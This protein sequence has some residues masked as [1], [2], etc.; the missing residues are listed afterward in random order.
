MTA[1]RRTSVLGLA[2]LLAAA[3]AAAD[4][5]VTAKEV[6]SC[7]VESVSADSV[8]LALKRRRH[9]TLPAW[10]V[11]EVRLSDTARVAELA[12]LL[13]RTKV[14]LDSGQSVPPPEVRTREAMR[15]RLDRTRE[16]RLEGLPWHADVVDTLARRTSPNEMAV[17]CEDMNAALLECGRSDGTVVQLLREVNREKEALYKI[18]PRAVTSDLINGGCFGGLVGLGAGAG[19]GLA[20]DPPEFDFW[21]GGLQDCGG[22]PAGATVGCIAGPVIGM[23]IGAWQRVNLIARHRNRVNDLVRRVNS[24]VVASP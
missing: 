20:I 9:R 17:R 23:A 6:I 4:T 7:S 16:S 10:D 1:I 3:T 18:R 15:L 22:C 5:V 13:P 11:Y 14:I 21:G 8:R 19:I 12:V 2:V 24:V